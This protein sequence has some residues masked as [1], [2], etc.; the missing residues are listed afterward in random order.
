MAKQTTKR[1]HW[2]S[3]SYLRSFAA[4]PDRRQK[5]WRFSKI[6][7]KPEL[8]PIENVAV[9]FHLY[10]PMGA[11][12]IRDD[13]LE[14]KLAKLEKWF[15]DP[16]WAAVCNDLPDLGWEPLR[17]MVALLVAVTYLRNPLWLEWTE[18]FHRQ[19]V[20]LIS[21]EGRPPD[22]FSVNGNETPMTRESWAA[23]SNASQEERKAAWNSM[24]SEAAWMAKELLSLRW[25]VIFSEQPVFITSDNPVMFMHPS[26]KFLGL[27][28]P[29][30]IVMFPLSQTRILTMDHRHSEPDS[31]YYPLRHDPARTNGLIWRDA[32][33]HMFS[34]RHPD[35]ICAEMLADAERVREA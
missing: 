1:C 7:G 27:S 16:I 18:S 4:D 9:K 24:V 19:V 33:D 17:K 2:V 14:K 8:K 34:S 32:I 26:L 31:C 12:G 22:R 10:S 30:T 29:E 15:G 3:Q 13:A 11:N 35:I 23:F 28:D 5:I 21:K 25:S 20:N 6:E